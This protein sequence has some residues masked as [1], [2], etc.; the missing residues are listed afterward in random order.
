M[1]DDKLPPYHK[2]NIPIR[3]HQCHPMNRRA[4]TLPVKVVIYDICN[5][6]ASRKLCGQSQRL[7]FLSCHYIGILSFPLV[8]E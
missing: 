5:G 8:W 7:L 3:G 4:T 1:P 6:E 2:R